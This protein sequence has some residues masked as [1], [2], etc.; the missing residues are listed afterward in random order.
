MGQYSHTAV[1]CLNLIKSRDSLSH[2]V[3]VMLAKLSCIAAIT[4]R[5]TFFSPSRLCIA[6]IQ[7]HV[8]IGEVTRNTNI[9][10]KRGG[11]WISLSKGVEYLCVGRWVGVCD[12]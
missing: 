10:R 4:D 8:C 9:Q 2:L 5:P 7:A 11:D 1:Q 6:N 12:R 3:F